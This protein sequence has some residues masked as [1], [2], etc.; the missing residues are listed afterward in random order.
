[1]Q[2]IVIESEKL[3]DTTTLILG[4]KSSLG[5]KM[6]EKRLKIINIHSKS[7]NSFIILDSSAA[8]INPGKKGN[9]KHIIKTIFENDIDTECISLIILTDRIT[10]QFKCAKSLYKKLDA[11]IVI[12]DQSNI[13]EKFHPD[14]IVKDDFDISSFGIDGK[15]FPLKDN[16]SS[17]LGVILS[18]GTLIAGDLL[19]I[20]KRFT[21]KFNTKKNY[22][23]K[24]LMFENLKRIL[25]ADPIKILNSNGKEISISEI[26]KLS[27]QIKSA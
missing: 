13:D 10:E 27:K 23:N 22:V 9:D 1:M 6:N 24:S 16:I 19:S 12:A 7:N 17:N 5:I 18:N 3:F 26:L 25:N 15:I 2:I 8:I 14:I 11:K 4:V 20:K 21:W